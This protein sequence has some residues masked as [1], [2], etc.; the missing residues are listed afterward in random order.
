MADAGCQCVYVV[1]SAGAL[2]LDVASVKML[3]ARWML[4]ALPEPPAEKTGSSAG[5][6]SGSGTGSSSGG[7]PSK[8]GDV[9]LTSAWRGTQSIIDQFVTPF[10]RRKGLSPGSTK[11]TPQQNAAAGGSATSD[12]LTTMSGSY[13]TDYPTTS[14]EAAARALA[15]GRSR[16]PDRGAGGAVGKVTPARWC[17]FDSRF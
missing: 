7:T 17:L 4:E 16:T 9:H 11:R 8:V 12:H 6:T 15:L 14:G 10:M 1:D 3:P 2:V 13:A 5:R